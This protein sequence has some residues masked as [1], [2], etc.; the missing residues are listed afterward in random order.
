MGNG[1][2][3][4]MEC[5]RYLIWKIK[6]SEKENG[7]RHAISKSNIILRAFMYLYNVCEL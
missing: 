7:M 2:A 1:R 4:T 3:G 5:C 6:T